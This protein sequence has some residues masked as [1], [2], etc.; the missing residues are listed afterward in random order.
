MS[1]N[2][3]V[4]QVSLLHP[5]IGLSEW[6]WVH[7]AVIC[8]GRFSV[9][10]TIIFAVYNPQ[11]LFFRYRSFSKL[12]SMSISFDFFY[13]NLTW[14][15]STPTNTYWWHLY[16]LNLHG[17]FFRCIYSFVFILLL[18]QRMIPTTKSGNSFIDKA[19]M[20][21]LIFMVAL[22][23]LFESRRIR[24]SDLTVSLGVPRHL[25]FIL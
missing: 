20:S 3:R 1:K 18:H 10:I 17:F 2:Y 16:L 11:Q 5:L 14:Y 7:E 8:F 6:S 25:I 4:W 24:C 15:R 23:L 21:Y 19:H 9:K 13:T 22:L 12:H